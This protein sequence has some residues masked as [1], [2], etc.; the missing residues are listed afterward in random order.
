[1]DGATLGALDGAVEGAADGATLG[2]ID[3][4]ADGTADGDAV[5]ELE[6][7][8]D[9][10]MLTIGESVGSGGNVGGG[11]LNMPALPNSSA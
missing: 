11:E 9:G 10:E 2:A 3:A 7:T 4:G 1:M 5:N 8:A 6:G